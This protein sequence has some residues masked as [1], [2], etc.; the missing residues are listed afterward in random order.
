MR[1]LCVMFPSRVEILSYEA[2]EIRNDL[3]PRHHEAVPGEAV[4]MNFMYRSCAW[5]PYSVLYPTSLWEVVQM[6]VTHGD[7]ASHCCRFFMHPTWLLRNNDIL[8]K[9][10][11]CLMGSG[12]YLGHFISQC[13]VRSKWWQI[14]VALMLNN[15]SWTFFPLFGWIWTEFAIFT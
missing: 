13:S 4:V 10:S 3:Q 5:R 15:I 7:I 6:F 9:C 2:L 1:L 12:T 8:S 11:L 14:A